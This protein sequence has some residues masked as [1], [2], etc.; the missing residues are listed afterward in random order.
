[1][2]DL[3]AIRA[4]NERRRGTE[5]WPHGKPEAPFDFKPFI[6]HESQEVADIAALL[7][8]V[9]GLNIEAF[10]IRQT[11]LRAAEERQDRIE[12]RLNALELL[13]PPKCSKCNWLFETRKQLTGH[14]IQ[15]ADKPC[16][17]PYA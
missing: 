10:A 8:E 11:M 9:E 5:Q 17:I 1:M 14:L 16:V 13:L 15:F 4:R 12:E 6:Q 2:I 7:A 3:E